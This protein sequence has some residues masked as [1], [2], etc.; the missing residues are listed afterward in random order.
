MIRLV[1][2]SHLRKRSS[3]Y[4]WYD[5]YQTGGPEALNDR[6]PR[7]DRVWN[8]IPEDVRERIGARRTGIVAAGVGR[9]GNV[10]CVRSFGL[11]PAEGARPDHQSR[12]SPVNNSVILLWLTWAASAGPN[13]HVRSACVRNAGG[14]AQRDSTLGKTSMPSNPQLSHRAKCSPSPIVQSG[15]SNQ[16]SFRSSYLGWAFLPS[17]II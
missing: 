4:R 17:G 5:L 3:F 13:N 6:S 8:R 10:F 11:P 7:S 2:Q 15:H 12:F 1:E 14:S 9:H 16:K